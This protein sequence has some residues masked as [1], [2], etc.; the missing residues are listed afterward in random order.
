MV[1]GPELVTQS[2]ARALA[3]QRD[4][5]ALRWLLRHPRALAHRTP[6]AR[7]EMLRAFGPGAHALLIDALEH[8]ARDAAMERAIVATLG[9]AREPL[10]TRAIALRLSHADPETRVAAARALGTLAAQETAHDLC[11]ALSDPAWAVRAQAAR[12]LGRMGAAEAI[13]PLGTG[14]E[15]RAWWV[16]HHSAYALAQLGAA[17]RTELDRIRL[18]SPDRYARE[19]AEEA[20]AA[21]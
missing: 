11:A 17:G 12:A 2:A 4:A 9:A 20:L 10:A 16:R 13:A 7:F 8:G 3:R 19:M 1:A 14:L 15:D 18:S 5:A 21:S 6:R